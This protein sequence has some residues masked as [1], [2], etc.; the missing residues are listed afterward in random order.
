MVSFNGE[1]C[2]LS[3]CNPT[4]INPYAACTCG[5][6]APLKMQ[7]P[8]TLIYAYYYVFSDAAPFGVPI[9]SCPPAVKGPLGEY[10]TLDKCVAETD[11][12]G[13]VTEWTTF[14]DALNTSF[15]FKWADIDSY[16][17][18]PYRW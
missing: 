4:S 18:F 12:Y 3:R 13:R 6:A 17:D 1:S 5:W 9:L 10:L 11:Q 7:P 15:Q 2:E 14:Y 8:S 16:N